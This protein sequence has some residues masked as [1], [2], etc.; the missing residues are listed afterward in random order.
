[1][2]VSRVSV[3]AWFVQFVAGVAMVST[4]P[5]IGLHIPF[6]FSFLGTMPICYYI[7]ILTKIWLR[8]LPRFKND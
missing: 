5:L 1:M 8:K 2:R 7:F 6:W 3:I 4:F